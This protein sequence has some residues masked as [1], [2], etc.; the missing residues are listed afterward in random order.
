MTK[1]ENIEA[2]QIILGSAIMRNRILLHVADIL[3]EK[4]FYYEEHK[5]IWREFIKI[6]KE[7]GTA[8][9]TTLKGCMKDIAFKEV[10]EHKYL[11]VLLDKANGIVDFRYYAKTLIE[12]WQKRELETLIENCQESLKNKSFS[13]LSSKLQN[14]IL[15]L[16]INN[17]IQKIKHIG[18]VIKDI[19]NDEKKLTDDFITTGFKELDNLM[20]GGFYKKQLTIIG[21]RPSIGKTS[22]AQQM[23]LKASQE[24]KKCLFISLEVDEKNIYLKFVSN[25]VS[26]QGWKLQRKILSDK[27]K[28]AEIEAMKELNEMDIYIND[29]SSLNIMQIENIVKK[30]LELQPIDVV[31]IDYIQIIR[32]LNQRNFNEAS[33]IKENTS[34]LKE[35]AKKYNIA[36]VALAQINR[37][38]VENKQEPS[39]NDLKGS[40]GIEEDADIAILLHRDKNED[41][42]GS[43]FSDSGKIIVAKNRHGAT[44]VVSFNFEGKFSRFITTVNNI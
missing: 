29:S 42:E 18:E 13:F 31:F 11:A 17:P 14:D 36:V 19:K 27:E 9:P 16:D 43:Y 37:K 35:I 22:M 34:R 28:K 33:A 6:G 7:G 25:L 3:E 12:L 30:Q 40:G 26:I 38:G 24:G 39:I 8:D 32:Y 41:E 5:I 2:E 21:A 44:G 10:G 20:N 15:K 23:I 1:Y 4:H